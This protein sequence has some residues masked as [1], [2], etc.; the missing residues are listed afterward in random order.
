MDHYKLRCGKCSKTFEFYP[1]PGQLQALRG[2]AM[3]KVIC[4]HCGKKAYWKD[5]GLVKLNPENQLPQIKPAESSVLKARADKISEAEAK[6]I[7]P[8]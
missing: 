3:V 6:P 1:T 8:Q 5:P 4:E 7:G 2:G